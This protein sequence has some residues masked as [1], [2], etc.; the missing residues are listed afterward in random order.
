MIFFFLVWAQLKNQYPLIKIDNELAK[1]N[2]I[3]SPADLSLDNCLKIKDKIYILDFEYFGW[4][5]P[6]KLA[7]DFYWH[8]SMNL[9]PSLK[10][11]WI[12]SMINIFKDDKFFKK[13]LIKNINYY[14]IRW[15]LIILNDFFPHILQKR[16][17][18]QNINFSDRFKY[19][20]KQL[21]KA[22]K[23]VHIIKYNLI[24]DNNFI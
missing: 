21:T 3:L 4:D 13:R 5:D 20:K 18:A 11:E 15:I 1:S 8:P 6:V 17:N 19:Y 2:Q 16:I 12:N 14:G 9:S 7:S 22:N 10:K 23:I 24:N